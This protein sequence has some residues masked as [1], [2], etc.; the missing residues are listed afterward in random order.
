MN[1][2]RQDLE[3]AIVAEKEKA[4]SLYEIAGFSWLLRA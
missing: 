4:R 1:V 3:E 2:L